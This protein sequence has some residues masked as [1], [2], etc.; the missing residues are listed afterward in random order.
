[1]KKRITAVLVVSTGIACIIAGCTGCAMLQTKHLR[2]ER[3]RVHQLVTVGQTIESAQAALRSNGFVLFYE[4]PVD[5]LKDGT[6]FQQLVRISKTGPT[7]DDTFFYTITGGKNP[8]RKES[9]YVV[10]EAGADGII[11]KVE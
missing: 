5:L 8:F 4:S 7:G 2:A 6:V 11:T 10:I 9:P 1:M 3:A